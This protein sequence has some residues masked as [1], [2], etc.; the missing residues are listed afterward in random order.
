MFIY[1]NYGMYVTGNAM[2]HN[3]HG[4]SVKICDGRSMIKIFKIFVK[5]SDFWEIFKIFANFGKNLNCLKFPDD[6]GPPD[7]VQ[8]PPDQSRRHFQ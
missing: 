8:G 1:I 2:N 3:G 5:L 6:P 4:R 7:R